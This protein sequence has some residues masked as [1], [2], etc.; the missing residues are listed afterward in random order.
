MFLKFLD[1]FFDFQSSSSFRIT[2]ISHILG[3]FPQFYILTFQKSSEILAVYISLIILHWMLI[4][5]FMKILF[6][7]LFFDLK[8]RHNNIDTFRVSKQGYWIIFGSDFHC[9][10][11]SSQLY[12]LPEL[13]F[14]WNQKTCLGKEW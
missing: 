9:K 6:M 12:R 3:D 7:K 14:P 8:I 11:H 13:L 10:N 5:L 4:F 2:K 1:T